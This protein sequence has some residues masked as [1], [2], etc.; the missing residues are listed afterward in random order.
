MP[1]SSL[2]SSDSVH[3][4]PGSPPSAQVKQAMLVSAS[5]MR[6]KEYICFTRTSIATATE[7]LH[8]R[9]LDDPVF[10]SM[11]EMTAR[12]KLDKHFNYKLFHRR[13]VY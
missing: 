3:C 13:S 9:S 1:L 4:L 2:K 11:V 5:A 8:V 10:L 6:A 12:T 7:R